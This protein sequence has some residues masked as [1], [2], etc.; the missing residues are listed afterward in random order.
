MTDVHIRFFYNIILAMKVNISIYGDVY[1][2]GT[3]T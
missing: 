2:S 1:S 3:L